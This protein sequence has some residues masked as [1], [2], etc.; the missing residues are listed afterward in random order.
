MRNQIAYASKSRAFSRST[1]QGDAPWNHRLIQSCVPC[2]A[3]R[4]YWQRQA[5]GVQAHVLVMRASGHLLTAG[6]QLCIDTWLF[7]PRCTW[8]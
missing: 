7:V 5:Q 3:M 6:Q 4:T 1:S 2:G 8:R